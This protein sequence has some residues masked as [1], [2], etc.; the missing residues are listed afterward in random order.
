MLSTIAPQLSQANSYPATLRQDD[1][2]AT[3]KQAQLPKQVTTASPNQ[4]SQE[5]IAQVAELKNRDMEVRQHEQ[6]HLSAAG[7][8]ATSGAN[9]SFQRGPDGASYAVGG[10][11]SIDT[12]DIQGDPEASLRKA[13]IIKRAALAPISPSSQDQKVAAQASAMANKAQAELIKKHQ[14]V[15]APE[16]GKE[17]KGVNFN[18]IA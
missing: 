13:D 16:M 5:E 11:V 12:S 10:E 15:T 18:Q 8:L 9:F 2:L 6:A 4:L 3:N 7:G 1:T 14:D 17:K